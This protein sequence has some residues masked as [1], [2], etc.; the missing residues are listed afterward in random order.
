[1]GLDRLGR[2]GDD[3]PTNAWWWGPLADYC[4]EIAPDISK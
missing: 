4:R 1:M 2:N 3:F